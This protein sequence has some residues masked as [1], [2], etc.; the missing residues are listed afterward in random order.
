MRRLPSLPSLPILTLAST[1]ASLSGQVQAQQ[2]ASTGGIRDTAALRPVVV[3]AT[4]VAVATAAPTASATVLQGAELRLRGVQSVADALRE[5]PGVAVV[6]QGSWGGVT[7]LFVRGGESRYTKVLIDGVPANQPGGQLDLA[8]LSLDDVERIEIVRGPGSVLYGSDA[9]SGVVQ[10]FTRQGRGPAAIRGSVRGGT[11]GTADADVG[12][13]G[14][15]SRGS[16]ALGA[17]HHRSAGLLGDT[18]ATARG[19]TSDVENGFRNTV[20]TGSAR[21]RPDARTDVRGSLRFNDG[22]FHY[23]TGFDGAIVPL[24]DATRDDRRL[25]ATLDAG[26]RL[27][28]R[29]ET[30]LALASHTMRFLSANL[31]SAPMDTLRS[32][33]RSTSDVFRRSADARVNVYVRPGDVLTGG[34]ELSGQGEAS[35]GWT[36][37]RTGPQRPAAPFEQTRRNVGYY[38]QWLGDVAGRLTY[39]VSGRIDDNQRFGTFTTGRASVSYAVPTGTKLRAAYGSAFKEPLFSE[40]FSTAFSR[41]NPELGPERSRSWELAVEQSLGSVL[42]FGAT[43]FDQRFR[44]MIQ[45]RSIP[46]GAPASDSVNYFNL[47]AA[48]ARGLEVEARV[49][50]R[51]NVSLVASYTL[52]RTRVVDPGASGPPSFARDS[53][54][55]RRPAHTATATATYRLPRRAT[56][57]LTSSYVGAR[58]DADFALFPSPRVQLAG[59]ARFD[60]AADL[61]VTQ[62]DGRRPGVALTVRVDNALDRKFEPVRRYQA[63][64]RVV[65][66]GARFGTP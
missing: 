17:A 7:S 35:E 33:S 25:L 51:G 1:L 8:F 66:V 60:A 5:V 39:A 37:A 2:P 50:E 19:V 45:F 23:P 22:R 65:L 56:F 24:Q 40:N 49:A 6:Q 28:A 54:L 62:P 42:T 44:D 64:G 46:R 41:G 15:W 11:F 52:L 48:D 14:G 31:P 36:Q 12:V 63:P 21:V 26:R 58:T 47:G 29:V 30:R 20:L 59:Y 16:Y 18:V 3:T 61:Q 10:I 43:Y 32:Y 13:S 38:A 34:I 4:R 55:L 53:A 57:A 9:I 27:G